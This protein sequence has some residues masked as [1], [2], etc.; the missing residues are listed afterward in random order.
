MKRIGKT[1]DAA[2]R[3]YLLLRHVER[4]CR[5][6]ARAYTFARK[7]RRTIALYRAIERATSTARDDYERLMHEEYLAS[8]PIRKP[9]FKIL[10]SGEAPETRYRT[11]GE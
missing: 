7:L 10:K 3:R 9:D 11:I 1:R 5:H 6:I 4:K 2:R 8:E